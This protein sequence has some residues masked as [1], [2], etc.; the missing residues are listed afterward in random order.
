VFFSFHAEYSQKGLLDELLPRV[1]QD[2]LYLA[3]IGGSIR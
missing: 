1:Q 2:L 3:R